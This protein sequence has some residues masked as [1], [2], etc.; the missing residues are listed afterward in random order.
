MRSSLSFAGLAV[1]VLLGI[2]CVEDPRSDEEFSTALSKTLT[3]KFQTKPDG[4]LTLKSSTKLLTCSE[5]FEGIAGERVTCSR[6]GEKLQVIVKSSGDSVVAVR[7]LSSKR[8]YYT[9]T[10]TGD[11]AGASR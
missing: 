10:R 11:V 1:A 6:S 9:C 2:G 5:R 3:L 8:G 4:T 7:D